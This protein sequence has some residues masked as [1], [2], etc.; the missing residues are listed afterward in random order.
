MN[1]K[2]IN[3][4]EIYDINPISLKLKFKKPSYFIIW[5]ISLV[6]HNIEKCFE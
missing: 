4:Y 1:V 3:K 6:F 2:E 5:N